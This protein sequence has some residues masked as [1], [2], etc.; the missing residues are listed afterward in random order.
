MSVVVPAYNETAKFKQEGINQ[1]YQYLKAQPFTFELIF[2]NDGS[3]DGTLKI[4]KL[5]QSEKSEVVV[6]DNPHQG[7]GPA[8][9]TG[10]LRATGENRLFADFDQ[11]TPIGEVEKLLPFRNKGYDVIIGSRE[12]KGAKREKEPL[13]RHLMGKGFNLL[14]KIF[15]VRGISDTQCGFK[16]FSQKATQDLFP[17]LRVVNVHKT[18]KDAL[19]GAIDVELLFLADKFGYKIAEVP[20]QWQH[21]KGSK[22]NPIKDS[23]RMFLEVIKIR[24]NDLLGK[25]DQ[26]ERQ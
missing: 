23:F 2:V 20:V 16:L 11:A 15:T 12:I 19:T 10:M 5:F 24:V 6:V 8:V 3:T 4:L 14:V 21:M 7:K 26:N 13:Y 25:Y 17:R 9:A 18:R 1:L 22:V